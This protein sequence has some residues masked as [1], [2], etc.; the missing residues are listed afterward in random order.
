LWKEFMKSDRHSLDR[1]LDTAL[2]KYAAVEP[3]AGLEERILASL[4]A[5]P[6]ESVRRSW[7]RWPLVAAA[8]AVV[9]V[10]MFLSLV[11]RPWQE[12]SVA[13]VRIPSSVKPP[14]V[15]AYT[16]EANRPASIVKHPNPSPHPTAGNSA[17]RL[18]QFPS[19][20]PLSEQ[21]KLLDNY[22]TE[23]RTQAVHLA[24]ARMASIQQDLAEELAKAAP[25]RD[26]AI[27]DQPSNQQTNR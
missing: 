19:P 22:V 15:P 11:F 20:R 9:I 25:D 24:R 7:W 12:P 6:N 5:E 2:T 26:G 17:P 13:M 3:R 18:E 14:V 4:R 23:N 1:E 21:E 10:V 8:S 16:R 27:S